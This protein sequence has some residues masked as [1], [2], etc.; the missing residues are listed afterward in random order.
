MHFFKL[1]VLK[2]VL[3][4]SVY[5]HH[6]MI[7]IYSLFLFQYLYMFSPAS[8][9]LPRLLIDSSSQCEIVSETYFKVK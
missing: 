4:V 7:K 3:A 9:P 5:N 2:C 6:I 8:T 1:I